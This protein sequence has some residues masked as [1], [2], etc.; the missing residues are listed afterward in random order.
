[1]HFNCEYKGQSPGDLDNLK[2]GFAGRFSGYDKTL[3]GPQD[4]K[5]HMYQ[6]FC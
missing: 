6:L 2:N 3:K 1:M 5:R 4:K